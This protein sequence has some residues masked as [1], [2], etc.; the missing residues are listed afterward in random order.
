MR[1]FWAEYGLWILLAAWWLFV[2]F[3]AYHREIDALIKRL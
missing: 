1:D 3:C 2:G